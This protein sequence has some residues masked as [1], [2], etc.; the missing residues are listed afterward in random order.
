MGLNDKSYSFVVQMG[1]INFTLTP[2]IFGNIDSGMLSKSNIGKLGVTKDA[3]D[4]KYYRITD[5]DKM[6]EQIELKY[7]Q[8]GISLHPDTKALIYNYISKVAESGAQL[9]QA[10]VGVPGTHAEVIA[11]NDLYNKVG[12]A[13][14]VKQG[15]LQTF[16]SGKKEGDFPACANCAGIIP[17]NFDIITGIK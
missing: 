11:L 15:Y 9:N 5:K 12:G 2:I 8:K 6:M 3:P 14:N 17:S 13:I 16:K 7:V 4:S 10:E 1:L